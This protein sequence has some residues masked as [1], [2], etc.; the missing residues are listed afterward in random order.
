[1]KD[2]PQYAAIPATANK[3]VYERLSLV[4][5][6]MAAV[7]VGKNGHNRDQNFKF[8]G[9]DD[10]YNTLA[11]ILG[12]H[13]VLIIPHRIEY[14]RNVITAASGKANYETIAKVQYLFLAPDGSSIV[15]ESIGEGRD[16]GDKSASK[17]LT[18]SYKYFLIH[19]LSIPLEGEIDPDAETPEES[20]FISA[21]QALEIESL[22]A[23][24]NT[25]VQDILRGFT[26]KGQPQLQSLT[27]IPA[28]NYDKIIKRLNEK[29]GEAK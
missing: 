5:R 27:E 20:R 6:D 1:M 14:T 15:G 4:Q 16:S 11:P 24:A 9:I 29:K 13:Q 18:M 2:L 8:R 28:V 12:R 7:G 3:L 17:A 10:V 23:Q 21:A 19:S 26:V 22:A 25:A